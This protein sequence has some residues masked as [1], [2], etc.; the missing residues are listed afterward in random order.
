MSLQLNLLVVDD[1]TLILETLRQF[2]QP[3]WNF[4][5][6]S[7]YSKIEQTVHVAF[8]DLH[9]SSNMQKNEG[10]DV[11]KNISEIHPHAEII[12][13][14]G[15]LNRDLME[16]TLKAGATRFLPKPLTPDEVT[17]TLD[18]LEAYFQLRFQQLNST[19][20]L[21]G[22]SDQAHFLRRQI[23][24]LK[25]EKGPIL[26]DAESGCG[27]DI[28]AQILNQQETTRPFVSINVSSIAETLFES[29]LFGYMRGAF[30][31]AQQNKIG[32]LEA[33]HGGDLFLDEIEALPLSQQPKLL[34]FLES[35]EVRRLGS[36]DSICVTTRII[37]A[38]NEDL[39]KKVQAGQFREDLYWRISGHKIKIPP[40]RERK[41]DIA[42]LCTFFASRAGPHRKKTFAPDALEALANYDWPGN[43]RELR[44][45]CEQLLLI[46]P[47]PLIR[48]EDVRKILTPSL[49][50]TQD[51][52]F[53]FNK[54]LSELCSEFEKR[55][56]IAAL[57]IDKDVEALVKLLKISRSSL[58]KKIKDYNLNL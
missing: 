52:K 41:T 45:V 55:A 33:A 57:H 32:L 12:A 20:D 27:K 42:E 7:N 51:F 48:Q 36:T 40:L 4:I 54:G 3:P 22:S 26:L 11:I 35:G 56:L 21:I 10:L 13:I 39:Q 8:V 14:S 49:P 46:S 19:T 31:G 23:A 1:D 50:E 28:V 29:E 44:R 25:G 34:R 43:I 6:Q 47:L 24:Q 58:Y 18:K 16:K 2:I 9:L 17:L 30:T 38:T 37:A 15:D 5:G 53:D